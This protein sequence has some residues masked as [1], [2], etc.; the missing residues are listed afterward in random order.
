MTQHRGASGLVALGMALCVSAGPSAGHGNDQDAHKDSPARS[1]AAPFDAA[2]VDVTPFGREG[3]PRHVGRTIRVDMTDAMRFT[4]AHLTVRRGETVRI[5][6]VNRG[7]VLHE[8]VLGTREELQKHAEL[9]RRFPEME[10]D[11]PHMVHV[12]PGKSGA[13]VWQFSAAGEFAFACLIP[14][15]SEAGMVG[16]VS[17]R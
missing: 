14:G 6:A 7:Q 10:H 17:V 2:K 5:V 12:K 16:T 15:H 3:D 4:P 8:L 1:A 11:E 9:M 13:I